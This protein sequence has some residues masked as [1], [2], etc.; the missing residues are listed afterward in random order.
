M[1]G[2]CTNCTRVV[3]SVLAADVSRAL[4]RSAR[5]AKVRFCGALCAGIVA[6]AQPVQKEL[7]ARLFWA[8]VAQL[9]E[10]LICNQRVGGSNPF[11]SSNYRQLFHSSSNKVGRIWLYCASFWQAALIPLLQGSPRTVL[12]NRRRGLEA[13]AE[14]CAAGG[15]QNDA[16]VAEWLKA[17]D[18]KSAT[19]RVTK[20]R[21]L[22][23]APFIRLLLELLWI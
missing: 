14:R 10:H 8:G 19:L 6:R 21:I 15:K 2:K 1:R 7:V 17:A 4:P 22:P 20:V 9:V 11:V 12:V 5:Y 3:A 23:C 13:S 16:Q 18:C